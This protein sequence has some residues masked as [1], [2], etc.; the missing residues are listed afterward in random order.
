MGVFG[1]YPLGLQML[2]L[3][4]HAE[5]SSRFNLQGCN[6]LIPVGASRVL[7]SLQ[8]LLLMPLSP[9]MGA[10]VGFWGAKPVERAFWTKLSCLVR[11]RLAV[12]TTI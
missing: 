11:S 2:P 4:C 6:E 7:S 5:I 10:F 3:F 1:N 12:I 9:D 8:L